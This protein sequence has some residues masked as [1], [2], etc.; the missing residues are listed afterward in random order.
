M[1]RG[2]EGKKEGER[3]DRREMGKG[4]EKEH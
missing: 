3:K 4:M 1:T 2:G